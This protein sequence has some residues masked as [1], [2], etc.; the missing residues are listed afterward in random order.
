MSLRHA[1][2]GLLVRDPASGYDLTKEFEGRSASSRGRRG[3]ARF[4]RS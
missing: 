4:T 2:L 3:T 1:L